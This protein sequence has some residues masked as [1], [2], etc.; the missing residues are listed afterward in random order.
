MGPPARECSAET[1][2]RPPGGVRAGSAA[3]APRTGAV[4]TRK[5]RDGG[6][7]RMK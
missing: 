4:W 1:M 3:C 6:G 7:G 5:E 2:R